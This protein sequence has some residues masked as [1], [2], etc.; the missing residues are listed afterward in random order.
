MRNWCRSLIAAAAAAILLV[1]IPGENVQAA[2]PGI[3][4]ILAEYPVVETDV[5]EASEGCV[6]LGLPGKYIQDVQSALTRINEIRLE[7]CREG[8]P[9]PGNPSVPL[10]EADYVPIR[11]SSDLEYIARIRAAES[12]LT[13]YHA[14]TNGLSGTD[15]FTLKSPNGIQS[16]GE[17]LAWNRSTSVISGIN[18]WYGEKSDWVKQDPDAVTGHY[19][20]MID[21]DHLYVGLGTFYYSGGIWPNSTA[22]E[23]SSRSNLDETPMAFS[24]NCIQLLEV[25]KQYLSGTPS[26]AGQTGGSIGESSRLA[27]VT[28]V[29]IP[30]SYTFTAQ[31]L[32]F[33]RGVA[34]TAADESVAAVNDSG[35]VTG[36]GCGETVITAKAYGIS[37]EVSY[38]IEHVYGGWEVTKEASCTENGLKV[39]RCQNCGEIADSE[40]I[41]AL[42]HN[43]GSWAVTKAAACE[44]DG[45]EHRVCARCSLEEIRA[46]PATGHQHTE[47]RGAKAAACEEDGY[48]GDLCCNDCGKLLE[49]GEVLPATGHLWGEWTLVTA[50]LCTVDGEEMRVCRHDS[51]HTERRAVPAPGHELAHTEAQEPTE[52]KNGNIEYWHCC[53]CEKYFSDEA[54][55]HEISQ[56]DTVIPKT[57][58]DPE[59]ISIGPGTAEMLTSHKDTGDSTL[60]LSIA[61]LPEGAY[62][63][64]LNWTS[65]NEKVAAVDENG[66][67]TA[68]TYGTAVITAED[69]EGLGLSVSCTV[70]T[71]YY[72]V[73]PEKYWAKHVYWAADAG[74]TN[75]FDGGINFGP[76]MSCT[77]EQMITFLWRE[78]GKPAVSKADIRKYNTFSDV[79]ANSYY[80]K[81]V[82]WA[83][84]NGITKGYSSGEHAGK[85]GVGFEVTRE[86]TVTFLY[87]MAKV[88]GGSS[89]RDV[90]AADLEKYTFKD[91]VSGKYYQKAV[92][93]AAKNSITKGYSSGEHTG[94]FGVGFSVLRGDIVTFLSRY[95]DKFN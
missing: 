89:F 85:F 64:Y 67:V 27:L 73:D 66:L 51:H 61:V 29:Q 26:I 52:R 76:E 9:T 62:M 40:V 22:G 3:L 69:T 14:R 30:S 78:A 49:K 74:I 38:S 92:V 36:I 39:I 56:T 20:Q 48:S 18:Q 86:D 2:D 79:E 83:A 1:F 15:I 16:W 68:L 91:I 4:D 11:W 81:P 31:G 28:D 8:V 80:E 55:E 93:W 87:R 44:E 59:A 45:E 41:P 10:T 90:T 7:A 32:P 17:V 13:M 34:W 60:Q 21:P 6:M 19:T 63:P 25:N 70:Q 75:G 54:C 12:A 33:M 65:S 43:F 47:L 24:G 72:D 42:G 82:V 57:G 5:T 88:L 46:V 50:P 58:I 35:T 37:A 23:F 95:D 77:R 53:V 84:K 94:K 71:R